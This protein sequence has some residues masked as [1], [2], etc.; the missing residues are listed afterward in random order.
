MKAKRKRWRSATISE[1]FDFASGKVQCKSFDMAPPEHDADIVIFTD[2]T[3]VS[4]LS[5]AHVCGTEYTPEM[6]GD[7]PLWWIYR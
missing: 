3:A 5:I 1:V 6:E 2:G 4:C 7:P